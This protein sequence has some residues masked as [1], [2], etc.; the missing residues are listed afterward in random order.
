M[1]KNA[2]Y[3]N[4]TATVNGLGDVT[5]NE[6]SKE[7]AAANVSVN[8]MVAIGMMSWRAEM[9]DMNKRMGELRNAN[10]EHGVWV[11]MVRGESEYNSVKNQYNQYQF[12]VVKAML[13]TIPMLTASKI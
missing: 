5:L 1:L 9:N 10:G 12:K 4:V 3:D 11:R 13:I 6:D 2:I 7:V 8:D